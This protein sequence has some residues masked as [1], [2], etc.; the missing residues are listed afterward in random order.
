MGRPKNPRLQKNEHPPHYKLME[1]LAE[2]IF[3]KITHLNIV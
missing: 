2:K 1:A 3:E